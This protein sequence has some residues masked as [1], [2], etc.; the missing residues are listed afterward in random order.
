MVLSNNVT[1]QK[2]ADM[3]LVSSAF[4]QYYATDDIVPIPEQIQSREFG[5]QSFE[6]G[7]VRHIGLADDH[8]LRKFLTTTPTSSYYCSVS[9][10]DNPATTPMG[11]KKWNGADL[12]F[13]IDAKDLRLDCRADHAV[14]VC[15]KCGSTSD[16]SSACCGTGRKAV[17]LPCNKCMGEAKLHA[18]RLTAIILDKF[19]A[20]PT[21]IKTYFSG[22]E[23]YHIHVTDPEFHK[24][25]SNGRERIVRYV[26]RDGI[27]VDAGMTTDLS[28]IFRMP[29]TL[30]SKSG[31]AKTECVDPFND[32]V[33]IDDT[34]TD[35]IADCPISF[36]LNGTGFGPYH[37]ERIKIP[38][39]AAV[40]MILKDMAHAI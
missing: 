26:T 7:W 32:G 30:S 19:G 39:Y 4:R 15:G 8:S 36:V 29:G 24:I 40:Y 31:M 22:N 6:I 35:I 3:M 2:T 13:D 16:V 27:L 12:V 23:G 9:Y 28:R 5:Y 10:Y 11:A 20:D 33:V 34:P 38:Q 25:E 1:D 21:M 17:S 18:D 37:N 14:H